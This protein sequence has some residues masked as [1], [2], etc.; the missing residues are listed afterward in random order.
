MSRQSR[1]LPQGGAI[2]RSQT[3]SF[4][5]DGSR[6]EGHPGDTLASAMLANDIKIFGRSFKYHR[7]RGVMSA[8]VEESGALITTGAGARRTPN[9]RATTHELFD[10][11][12]AH[13]QNAWP[14]VRFDLNAV[15]GLFTRF[16]SAGFYYKTFMSPGRGTW[17]WMQYEKII[18]NAA[19]MGTASREPD[20]DSYEIA[21]A[22]CD[23]LVVGSGPAGLE[24]ARVAA[25]AGLH[26]I[27]AEQD[28]AIAPSLLSETEGVGGEAPADWR[29]A[30]IDALQAAGNVEI[31]P[32]TTVFG[33]FDGGVAGMLERVTDHLADPSHH[34]PRERF[35][36]VRAKRTIIATGA[37]ERTIAFGNN[38]KPG[39]MLANAARI[40][41]NRFGVAAGQRAV[42]AT[43]NDSGYHSALDMAAAGVNVAKILDVRERAS[44]DLAARARTAGIEIMTSCVPVETAGRGAVG[45]LR[46]GRRSGATIRAADWIDCDLVA[47]SG[48]WTPVVNLLSHRGMRPVYDETLATFLPGECAE[49]IRA[50]G[51]AAGVWRTE[52][53]AQSGRAA[54]AAAARDLGKSAP[55]E[56]A[57]APGGWEK[58]IHPLWEV[59]LE[60]RKLKSFVDP[61]HDVKADDVRLAH[62][63]GYVS[64]EHLKRYTTL[65]MASDQGK[66]GNVI[67][68]ALMADATGKTIPETG[69]TM[70]RPPY[71]PI[72]LG[73]LA[74]RG[75]DEHFRATRYTPM[76]DWNMEHGAVMIDAGLWKRPWYFPSDGEDLT[77]SY[78][79]ET[80]IVRKT[81]GLCDVTSLGKI[82]VQGPDAAE[83]LNRVYINGYGKLPVGRARYGIML[84]D[85]GIVMD[86]G[87][88]WR[89]SDTDFFMTTTTANAVKVMGFLEEL[90]E[91]R[92]PDLRVRVT[93]VS[94]QW[95]GLAVAGPKARQ[96]LEAVVKDIDMSNEAFPFMGVREGR[97][98]GAQCRIARISFSGEMAY[99]AYVPSDY[100]AALCDAVWKVAEPLGGIL[101]GTEALGALR[102][103]KGHV[104][105]PELDGRTTLEDLHLD[106]MASSKKP[107]IGNVLRKRPGMMADDRP[108]L[109]GIM[110]KDRTQRL[111]AGALLHAPDQLSGHG[112][113]WV[114]SVTYSPELGHWIALGLIRGGVDA[115]SGKTA[116]HADPVR[117]GNTEVEITATHFVDPDGS[118]M[119]A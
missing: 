66:V 47:V 110:P 27:L 74:G 10:G 55:D 63:E 43:N 44:D 14:S 87:T 12:D 32:R 25:E 90:L 1:R 79:R 98:G 39:V 107:F 5:F 118:R 33:L 31:M 106:R 75:C 59:R 38:D 50:A 57:P 91:T 58:S 52:D 26:V 114:T 108:Q 113:G 15:N 56:K 29:A 99:E 89:L 100:A 97:I 65:G 103:E 101:Y 115:W 3:I 8:G 6:H 45:K 24:A 49:P 93:T 116:I 48:G 37:L 85:D 92:W 109:V 11:L 35:W 60:G 62:Q 51:S 13:G 72:S 17:A 105:G 70:F 34:L 77:A 96:V 81:V 67:G 69:T 41:A 84:R 28:F 76:H 82:A 80:E 2:D 71:T 102:I 95:A 42:V 119:H 18:R 86:D 36:V 78:E 111:Y 94:E 9:V 73:A 4:T 23:V 112:E 117:S 30:R 83:F 22:H 64:V 40:Y 20:P 53:C 54:G 7:P 68:L 88:T 19:G 61:Q 16:F 46:V 21:H 104:A